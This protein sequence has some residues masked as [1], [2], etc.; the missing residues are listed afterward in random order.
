MQA[1]L[2]RVAT[3]LSDKEEGQSKAV[4]DLD[5]DDDSSVAA[6][7]GASPAWQRVSA[8]QVDAWRAHAVGCTGAASVDLG[9]VDHEPRL[10]GLSPLPRRAVSA[11]WARNATGHVAG[12]ERAG[13]LRW[14]GHIVSATASPPPLPH[15]PASG[16]VA[17]LFG[18]G[19]AP[20]GT[21]FRSR[22]VLELSAARLRGRATSVERGVCAAL[23]L[24]AC[25]L[26]GAFPSSHLFMHGLSDTFTRR[27]AHRHGPEW[28]ARVC[29]RRVWSPRRGARC[30]R[31][32]GCRRR[33]CD[34]AG[35][36]RARVGFHDVRAAASATE[37]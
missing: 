24:L 18:F 26:R 31:A 14:A 33:L 4:H 35:F 21:G 10:D 27:A 11:E 23:P 16:G 30:G 17:S 12:R 2:K 7:P 9:R 28:T 3:G 20:R 29:F 32:L 1:A 36:Q 37:S 6:S 5:A 22:A 34:L 15:A 25:L 13:S 19:A 8:A